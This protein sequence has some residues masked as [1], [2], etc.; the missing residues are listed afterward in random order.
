MF[1]RIM[2]YGNRLV[3]CSVDNVREGVWERRG[4]ETP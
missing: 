1:A 3:A 2:L 4:R